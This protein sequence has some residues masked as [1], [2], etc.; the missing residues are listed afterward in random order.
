MKVVC[1]RCGRIGYLQKVRVTVSNRSYSY[2]VVNHRNSMHYLGK[3][4]RV[5]VYQEHDSKE[6]KPFPLYGANTPIL[7]FILKNF[8]PHETYVE[9]FGGS[10]IV[11]LTK[12]RSKIEIYNDLSKD[13]YNVFLCLRDHHREVMNYLQYIPHS[14]LIFQDIVSELLTKPCNPPDPRRAALYMAYLC[15]SYNAYANPREGR[16]KMNRKYDG[17]DGPRVIIYE[18][19]IPKVVK[20]LR[21]V[22]IENLDF[23]ECIRKYDSEDTFFYLDPPH[24]GNEKYYEGN[25]T[26]RDH[27]D[28]AKILKSIKGKFMLLYSYHDWVLE[29]YR[30]FNILQV[31]YRA[32]VYVAS[33]REATHPERTYLLVMNY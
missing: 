24:I 18:R 11:L 29:T 19:R 31:K 1:P 28:L 5:E 2:Y 33:R 7:K 23:R 20:R 12:S 21:Y 15:M 25:F 16:V 14:R 22:Q 17:A 30:E 32:Q 8:P 9:V 13:L 26:M 10:A 6:I 3:Y 4:A 27:E